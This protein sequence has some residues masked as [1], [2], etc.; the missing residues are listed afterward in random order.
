M[1]TGESLLFPPDLGFATC[2]DSSSM[3]VVLSSMKAEDSTE[4]NGVCRIIAEGREP[5]RR[6]AP[7]LNPSFTR[8]PRY[9]NFT[10]SE[11]C[12]GGCYGYQGEGCWW[13]KRA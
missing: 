2:G 11:T 7:R 1:S 12:L 5:F 13:S 10:N 4:M 8:V 6:T 3:G 9:D